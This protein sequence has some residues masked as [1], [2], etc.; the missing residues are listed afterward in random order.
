MRKLTQNERWQGAQ[1]GYLGASLLQ[2]WTQF[3]SLQNGASGGSI[4]GTIFPHPHPL[5]KPA[6][7][8]KG[9]RK[10]LPFREALTFPAEHRAVI[11]QEP[12]DNGQSQQKQAHDGGHDSPD[13]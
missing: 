13:V 12:G 8:T 3:G 10:S 6:R 2:I 5:R 9:P 4:T 1:E 11:Q 7:E